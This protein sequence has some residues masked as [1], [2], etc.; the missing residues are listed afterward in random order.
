MTLAE[1]ER[2]EDLSVYGINETQI[3]QTSCR[4][5][6]KLNSS[7]E[8][9]DNATSRGLWRIP[10]PAGV[11]GFQVAGFNFAM[12]FQCRYIIRRERKRIRLN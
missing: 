2:S 3:L 11:G 8:A 6:C 1:N 9:E 5:I 12:P 4:N 7:R 10:P